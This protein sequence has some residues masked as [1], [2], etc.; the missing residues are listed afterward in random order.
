ML[1]DHF[2]NRTDPIL[3]ATEMLAGHLR[4]ELRIKLFLVQII[5]EVCQLTPGPSINRLKISDAQFFVDAL[6]AVL[7]EAFFALLNLASVAA[8]ARTRQKVKQVGEQHLA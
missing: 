8:T 5:L 2:I 7:E 1:V 6:A 3:K 4:L